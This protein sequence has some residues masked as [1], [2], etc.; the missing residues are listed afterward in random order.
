MKKERAVYIGEPLKQL[1]IE[2]GMSQEEFAHCYKL[3]RSYMSDLEETQKVHP[4]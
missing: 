2:T 1:R 3:G 4:L